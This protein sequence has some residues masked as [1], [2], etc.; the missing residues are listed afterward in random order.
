[1][2][3]IIAVNKIGA[4][5]ANLSAASMAASF[6]IM[7]LTLS[8]PAFMVSSPLFPSSSSALLTTP[9]TPATVRIAHGVRLQGPSPNDDDG[10]PLTERDTLYQTPKFEF[11]AVTITALLGGAIAFQFF[12]LANL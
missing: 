7:A 3:E 11:D 9:S 2:L 4:E 8:S 10:K 1:M 5:L 12:V 6:C